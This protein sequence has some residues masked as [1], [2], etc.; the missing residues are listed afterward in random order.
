MVQAEFKPQLPWPRILAFFTVMPYHR[1]TRWQCY[2]F[3][4]AKAELFKGTTSQDK[5]RS[6]HK[7]SSR[8]CGWEKVLNMDDFFSS[9]PLQ[10]SSFMNTIFSWYSFKKIEPDWAEIWQSVLSYPHRTSGI[11]SLLSVTPTQHYF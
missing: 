7:A 4:T 8:V 1:N 10:I 6:P 3:R 5:M 9:F 11:Q 2:L